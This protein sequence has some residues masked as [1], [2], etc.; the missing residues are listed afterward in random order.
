MSSGLGLLQ[1][2]LIQRCIQ[3]RVKYL[4][5]SFL[6]KQ[7]TAA[8]NY[9]NKKLYLRYLTGFCIYLWFV[10]QIF[11]VFLPHSSCTIPK[12]LWYKIILKTEQKQ[13]T[14]NTN[15]RNWR[16]PLL[17]HKF[18]NQNEDINKPWLDRIKIN[19]TKYTLKI[20]IQNVIHFIFQKKNNNVR[21]N[22]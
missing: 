2:Y 18:S 6:R 16:E 20:I 4:R 14:N 19:I 1:F 17:N 22:F 7:L 5:W 11:F 10:C 21:K 9:F 13:N 3:N 12:N 15:L 8:I